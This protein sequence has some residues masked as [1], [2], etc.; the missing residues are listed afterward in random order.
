MPGNDAAAAAAAAAAGTGANGDAAARELIEAAT[1]PGEDPPAAVAAAAATAAA[2]AEAAVIEDEDVLTA[3]SGVLFEMD[4]EGGAT[5]NEVEARMPE[6]LRFAAPLI[7]TDVGGSTAEFEGDSPP[8]LI[9]RCRN[10]HGD[11]IIF[12]ERTNFLK[13]A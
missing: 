6:L 8:P 1:D 12:T 11:A 5:G 10:F 3:N 2:K 7:T 4:T 13:N 9:W